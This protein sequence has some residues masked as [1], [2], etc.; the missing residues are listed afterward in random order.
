[1][2]H[3][4]RVDDAHRVALAQA[5]E[6]GD[7]LAVELGVIEPEDDELYR[8]DRHG[9]PFVAS[10]GRFMLAGRG[11]APHHPMRMIS[12][13]RS[14]PSG[15]WVISRTERSPAASNTSATRS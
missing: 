14:R 9:A 1:L 12:S 5:L 8:P 13:T 10:A 4:E 3:R 2:V 7:D 6:L 15:R 11:G